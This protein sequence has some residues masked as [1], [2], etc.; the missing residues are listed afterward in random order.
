MKHMSI[1]T[2]TIALLAILAGACGGG[3]EPNE[4]TP[5]T[6]DNV[7]CATTELTFESIGGTQQVDFTANHEWS[8]FATGAEWININPNNGTSQKATITITVAANTNYEPR[9]ATMTILAGSARHN[10]TVTQAAAEKPDEPDDSDIVCPINGYKLVWNDEFNEGSVP[11]KDWTHEVKPDHW[12]NNELQN[13]VNGEVNGKR[14]TIVSDGTLKIRCFKDGNK[15]YSGRIYAKRN[16]GWK[17]G[18]MQARIKLPKGKG[19]WPAFWMMPVN[20]TSWPGDGEI[21]IMEEVGYNPNVVYSTI[22]CNKYNNTGTSIESAHRR[23]AD[24][25]GAFHD[26]AM[27][28]TADYMTFYVDGDKLL[29]YYNDGTGKNAWPFFTD[30]YI[31][32]NLAWGGDWGGQQGVDESAL[33]IEM[34]VDYVRVFQK[35]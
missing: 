33:P 27:E 25:E 21:D 22:H 35:N 19:T 23:L 10:I 26:Y 4:P 12:V 30:F 5:A 34:E 24:A 7:T 1:I 8:V 9:S 6:Q 11:G 29:T 17:Y 16:Q 3:D 18:Y 15:I 20:F 31:I 13:Y 32:L 28:W 2:T 14:V